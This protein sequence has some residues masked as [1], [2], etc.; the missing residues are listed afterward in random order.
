MYVVEEKL[1]STPRIR[2][3]SGV[4]SLLVTAII[5]L[6]LFFLRI[7]VPDPPFETK[8][9][10][11]ELDFG[12]VDGGFG[13]PDQG[14]PSPTP[15]AQGSDAGDGGSP[16][17]AGGQGEVVN[18]DGTDNVALPPIKPPASTKPSEDP[19]LKARL[20]KIGKRTGT[21]TTGDPNGW[22]GGSGTTGSGKG[23]NNGGVTGDGG[24][25]PGARGNGL[26]STNFTN[27]RLN[28]SVTKVD[29]DGWGNIVVR[30]RVN[31]EGKP[32]ILSW[33]EPGTTYTG[34]DAN[35]RAVFTYFLSHSYFTK[36]GETC[37]ESGLVTLTVKQGL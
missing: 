23:G 16:S 34:T 2:L 20:G 21:G 9:G 18:N 14:G 15:P 7:Y 25:K 10:E 4:L 3:T 6:L 5:V 11:L 33:N 31:C 12:M 35:M 8:K 19:N 36:T 32:S 13:Q 22:P 28:S 29:N 26:Y 37:P 30:L 27:F 1:I 17:Q 24:K